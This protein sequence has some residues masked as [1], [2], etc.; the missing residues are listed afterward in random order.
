MG[1]T[2]NFQMVEL[3]LY[4]ASFHFLQFCIDLTKMKLWNDLY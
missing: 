1:K 3:G 2:M 4:S